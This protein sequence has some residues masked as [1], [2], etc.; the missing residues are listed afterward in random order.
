MSKGDWP[1]PI[2]STDSSDN[3]ICPVEYQTPAQTEGLGTNSGLKKN[4]TP[5]SGVAI[6]TGQTPDLVFLAVRLSANQTD[7]TS[8]IIRG[9]E[10]DVEHSSP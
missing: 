7:L 5:I 9:V 1:T 6:L 2:L 4:D 10:T 8:A 3:W